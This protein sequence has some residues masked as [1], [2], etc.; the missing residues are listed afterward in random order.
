MF[1]YTTNAVVIPLIKHS[2]S[3]D[4]VDDDRVGGS[5]RH[6]TKTYL[7][8]NRNKAII[9]LLYIHETVITGYIGN[10]CPRQHRRHNPLCTY[11]DIFMAGWPQP[12]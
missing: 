11:R 4:D 7:Q 3:P 10:S 6:T 1:R 2:L 5:R 8:K 9:V 12:Q